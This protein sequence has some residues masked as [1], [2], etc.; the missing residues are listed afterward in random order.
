MKVKCPKCGMFGVYKHL[1]HKTSRVAGFIYHE[2]FLGGC[3]ITL[4]EERKVIITPGFYW[5]KVNEC[6]W[7]VARFLEYNQWIMLGLKRIQPN[8]NFVGDRIERIPE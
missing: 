8:P 6:C 4:Q 7:E 5:I 2:P 3:R 1:A